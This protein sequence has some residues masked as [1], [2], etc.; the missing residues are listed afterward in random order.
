[1]QRPSVFTLAAGYEEL[2]AHHELRNDPLVQAVIGRD[3]QLA[4]PNTLCRFENGIERQACIELSRL[5]VEFFFKQKQ[6]IIKPMKK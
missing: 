6:F 5:F 3:R 4:T 1:M 2:N